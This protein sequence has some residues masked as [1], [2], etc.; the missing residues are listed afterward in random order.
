MALDL[1]AS[2]QR[3]LAREALTDTLQACIGTP[4]FL[5]SLAP[6]FR[7]ARTKSARDRSG[8]VRSLERT[9]ACMT[10]ALRPGYILD[11]VCSALLGRPVLLRAEDIDALLPEQFDVDEHDLWDERYSNEQALLT[12]TGTK[13]HA[14]TNFRAF[15]QLA[16]IL[17]YIISGVYSV[18][19]RNHW[20]EEQNVAT[21]QDL[22][23]QL[24]DWRANLPPHLIWTPQNNM[25]TA[26]H[27][28]VLHTVSI[29]VNV[30]S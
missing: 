28:Q 24:E 23:I 17:E 6:S 27:I 14:L 12:F 29:A 10:D 7:L 20:R 1:G 2:A 26:P 3:I 19:R 18:Q 4:A 9:M 22:S 30:F 21:L 5:R 11:K 8:D 25:R 16:R 13:V 15:A